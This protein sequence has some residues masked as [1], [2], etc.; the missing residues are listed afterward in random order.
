MVYRLESHWP[1]SN[2]L[3]ILEK[4]IEVFISLEFAKILHSILMDSDEV[5]SSFI[6]EFVISH[7]IYPSIVEGYLA[8][9]L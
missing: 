8:A 6:T 5:L 7:S 1:L 3:E 9:I 2:D 4:L